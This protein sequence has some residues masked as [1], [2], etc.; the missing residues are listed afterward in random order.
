MLKGAPK[1][2][3]KEQ[4]AA[5]PDENHQQDHRCQGKRVRASAAGN[6]CFLFDSKAITWSSS[7]KTYARHTD[8]THEKSTTGRQAIHK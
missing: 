5:T 6:S 2:E 8:V 7:Y 4:Q 1:A 3:K